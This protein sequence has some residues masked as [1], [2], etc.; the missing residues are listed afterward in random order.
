MTSAVIG[1]GTLLKAGDGGGPEVFTTIAEV[2]SISGPQITR[3][4]LDVTNMDSVGNF[5]EFVSTLQDG[6][7]VSFDVNYIGD[8]T[9]QNNMKTDQDNGT[10]RNFQILMPN[11][12][13]TLFAF[14]ALV[15]GNDFNFEIDGIISLSISLKITGQV[16]IT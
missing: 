13:A 2:K 4:T 6:G 16:T 12:G 5:R 9:S 1:K 10:A 11:V 15:V 3:D 8:N 7:T 14:T